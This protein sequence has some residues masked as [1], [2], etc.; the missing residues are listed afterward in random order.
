MCL[1]IY[2]EFVAVEELKWGAEM[3]P[4]WKKSKWF[5]FNIVYMQLYYLFKSV[6]KGI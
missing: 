3:S 6:R 4:F 2:E 5:T 1:G